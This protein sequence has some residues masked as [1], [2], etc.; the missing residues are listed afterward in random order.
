MRGGL[1]EDEV[2][3]DIAVKMGKMGRNGKLVGEGKG[4]AQVNGKEH[5]RRGKECTVLNLEKQADRA[6]ARRKA[7]AR[8]A[9]WYESGLPGKWYM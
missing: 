2:R 9:F 5:G 6:A 3:K 4:K 1:C 8:L 7:V